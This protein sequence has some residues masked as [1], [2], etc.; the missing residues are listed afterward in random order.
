MIDVHKLATTPGRRETGD[1][2]Q[3]TFKRFA[4]AKHLSSCYMF[5]SDSD[6]LNVVNRGREVETPLFFV[7]QSI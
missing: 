2:S 7:G 1:F 3:P 4:A 6:V 5:L